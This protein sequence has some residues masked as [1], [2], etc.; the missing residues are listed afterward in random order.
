MHGAGAK[1]SGVGGRAAV[2][3]FARFSI[4]ETKEGSIA[5]NYQNLLVILIDGFKN[6]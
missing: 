1:V 4:E 6:S 3:K 2:E 5:V